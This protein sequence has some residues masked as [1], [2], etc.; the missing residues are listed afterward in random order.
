MIVDLIRTDMPTHYD[1]L[2]STLNNL[3]HARMVAVVDAMIGRLTCYRGNLPACLEPHVSLIGE[4]AKH[5]PEHGRGNCAVAQLV[6]GYIC[7]SDD[8]HLNEIA[9]IGYVW[10][11][12]LIE[13]C[14]IYLPEF[15]AHTSDSDIVF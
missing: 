11:R 15:E 3:P 7:V 9:Q 1:G 5:C 10:R 2:E 14:N 12:T 8:A 6:G 13:V 4:V